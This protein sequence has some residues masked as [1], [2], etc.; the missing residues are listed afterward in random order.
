MEN[1]KSAK[2]IKSFSNIREKKNRYILHLVPCL[3][4]PAENSAAKCF[5]F[6]TGFSFLISTF[7]FNNVKKKKAKDQVELPP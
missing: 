3:Y 5:F 1:G 6:S 2:G 4:Q 7:L